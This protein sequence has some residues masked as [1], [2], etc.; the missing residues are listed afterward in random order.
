MQLSWRMLRDLEHDFGEAFFL[1]DLQ[2]FRANYREFLGAFRAI[3][4][5]SEI[6][7]SY[8]TNYLPRLCRE[9]DTLGG[10]AEVVSAMEYELALQVGVAPHRI[11]FNG[12]C[13]RA[14]E[15][16]RALLAGSI[17]NLD[18]DYEVALVETIARRWPQATLTVGLRCNFTVED[19]HISRFGLDVERDLHPAVQRLK[20]IDNCVL[21]GLHCHFTTGQRSLESY[22]L[23]TRRLLE[24]SAACFQREPPRLID[25]GGG[26]FGKMGLGLRSQYA[27]PVPSY[28]EYADA[29][30]SEVATAY[31]DIDGPE[32]ILEPGTALTAD[33]V[34][35][36]AKVITLK[37]LGS[38]ALA[39]VAGSIHNIKPTLHQ[40][41]L[42]V[43]VV[44]A[45]EDGRGK[46][47]MPVDI[48]GYTCMEHDCLYRGCE[49][50]MRPGDYVVFEN[51]GAYTIVMKPP[52]IRPA[53]AV[54]TYDGGHSLTVARR[55]EQLDDLLTT[56]NFA[57]K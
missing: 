10:Y 29:I 8:K 23:R 9:V 24:L 34:R 13:K 48:V 39:L 3:Y 51:V 40:K 53:P 50:A 54:L 25:V 20:S 1:L 11:I 37:R 42:P 15:L 32:L 41:Q 27:F 16:E 28:E 52:F 26:F 46:A 44:R 35:F 43:T 17:V 56:Y 6:A 22:T 36:V 4:P 30:A 7:Y 2:A 31:T 38:R 14:C 12:P 33:A 21:A 55:A 5:R 45:A 19:D 47:E 57:D 49:D 18:S